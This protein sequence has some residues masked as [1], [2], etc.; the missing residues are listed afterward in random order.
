[1]RVQRKGKAGVC[2]EALA[3]HD[4]GVVVPEADNLYSAS[5]EVILTPAAPYFAFAKLNL[6]TILLNPAFEAV[7]LTYPVSALIPVTVYVFPDKLPV[8]FMGVP[9]ETV[10]LAES[11]TPPSIIEKVVEAPEKEPTTPFASACK[12]QDSLERI[13]IGASFRSLIVISDV[14]FGLAIYS[15]SHVITA[16]SVTIEPST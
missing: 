10:Q 14:V 13:P 15:T 3:S 4:D 7:K 12:T 5:V 2:A 16:L 8:M 6:F 11:S 1:M 9:A